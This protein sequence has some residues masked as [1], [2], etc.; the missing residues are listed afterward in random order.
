MIL[1]LQSCQVLWLRPQFSVPAV[2]L[3][4]HQAAT[5]PVQQRPVGCGRW[6]RGA[7]RSWRPWRRRSCWSP[8]RRR[9]PSQPRRHGRRCQQ[10][11]HTPL[12]LQVG[13]FKW[14]KE[15]LEDMDCHGP[16]M[17]LH[18]RDPKDEQISIPEIHYLYTETFWLVVGQVV[19]SQGIV[20]LLDFFQKITYFTQC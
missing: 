4:D 14:H 13:L 9:S 12:S 15:V 8:R 10:I 7:R 2:I 5:A 1:I 16:S 11:R 19:W 20:A 17:G 18:L 6:S 3:P